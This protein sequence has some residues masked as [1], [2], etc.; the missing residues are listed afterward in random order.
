MAAFLRRSFVPEAESNPHPLL[1]AP[2]LFFFLRDFYV[3][4]ILDPILFT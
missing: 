3:F 4:S 1:A 2:A